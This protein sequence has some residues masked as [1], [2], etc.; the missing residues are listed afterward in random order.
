MS[1]RDLLIGSSP[2]LLDGAM[3]TQLAA[4]GLGPGGSRNLTS[5][6]AVRDIH[7]S[8]IRAGARAVTTNTLTDNRLFLESHAVAVD[9]AAIN[10][11]G[12]SLARQA[13]GPTA[14]VLGDMGSTGQLLEPYGDYTEEQ[15]TSVFREQARYLAEAGV[16]GYIIET[17]MDLRE[18]LCALRACREV[19]P[20]PVFVTLSFQT[21]RDGGRT[22]M[23][24]SAQQAAEA[25]TRAGAAA[26]G[27]NCGDLDPFE[28]AALIA[29]LREKTDLPLVAQPNAGKPRMVAGATVFDMGPDRFAEGLARCVESGA[30]LVGGCC[31][32]TPAHIAAA[33]RMLG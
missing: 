31:G 26:I 24:S 11:A 21:L 5:P 28:T 23:G 20:L 6:D 13:A 10:A 16:D 30:H 3:G 1:L 14:C 22:A 4:R 12:V 15:F 19:S 9:V 32:T 29:L 33:A 17:M 2:V 27:S 7:A 18:A 8:Y 25:L